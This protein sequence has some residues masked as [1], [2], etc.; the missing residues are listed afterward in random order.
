MTY[1]KR[2]K[3]ILKKAIELSILADVDIFLL[4][5]DKKKKRCVHFA[6]NSKQEL[7]TMFNEHCHRDFFSN[8]DYARVGGRQQ[9]IE[10]LN[11][12]QSE[13]EHLIPMESNKNISQG[14]IGIL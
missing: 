6:S 1:C 12:S 13:D 3:G 14:Q 5:H 2:K 7:T 11:L 8:S 9:D 4:I 10:D